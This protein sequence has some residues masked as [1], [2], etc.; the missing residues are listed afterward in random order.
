MTQEIYHVQEDG[1]EVI[2]SDMDMLGRVGA[3]GDDLAMLD[4]FRPRPFDGA[5]VFKAILPY[6]FAGDTAPVDGLVTEGETGGTVR[7]MPFK[8]MVGSRTAESADAAANWND[9]RGAYFIGDQNALDFD[10]AIPANASG[11]ARIDLVYAAIAID[12]NGLS[13][14][15]N[16][17]DPFSGAKTPDVPVTLT[18]VQAVTVGLQAGTADPTPVVPS[19]PTDS[20]DVFNIPIALLAVPNGWGGSSTLD[21]KRILLIAPTLPLS[22]TTGGRSMRP[23]N[24]LYK[25]GGSYLT[26]ARLAAWANTGVRPSAF[27]PSTSVGD[28]GLAIDLDLQDAS[29]ANWSHVNGAVV[30]DSQDWGHRTAEWHAMVN[31]SAANVK[32]AH[33]QGNTSTNPS[34]PQALADNLGTYESIGMGQSTVRDGNALTGVNSGMVMLLTSAR[35]SSL[36][37]AVVGLYVDY[38]DSNKLKLYVSGVPACRL[39][40]LLRMSARYSNNA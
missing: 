7:V 14:V 28:E 22:P 27:V 10:L 4:I 19:L 34:V 16:V 35:V 13:G 30:D 40:V 20:G 36:G 26:T 25:V 17:R 1:Q 21:K 18:L 5:T 2:K 29:S 11:N 31:K 8:A 32:F 6:G 12:A 37:A 3:R 9:L 39:H 24:S 23:A 38:A 15:R 33:D